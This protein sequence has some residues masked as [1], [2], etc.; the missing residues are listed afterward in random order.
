MNAAIAASPCPRCICTSPRLFAMS[1]ES[2]SRA[3]ALRN[4]GFGAVEIAQRLQ[5]DAELHVGAGNRGVLRESTR[6]D[7]RPRRACRRARGARRRGS[8]ALRH[9]ADRAPRR[10]AARPARHR[11][12][13]ST[14]AWRRDDSARRRAAATWPPPGGSGRWRR[15]SVRAGRARNRADRRRGPCPGPARAPLRTRPRRRP[16]LPSA[17]ARRRGRRAASASPATASAFG[18]PDDAAGTRG[19]R[20]G[21]QEYR[22]RLQ[23]SAR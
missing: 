15:P 22:Q 6:A 11:D 2:G 9:A 19:A 20:T 21:Q 7:V 18:C 4:D 10:A 16:S 5:R 23:S 17:R 13:A 12:R 8:T 14:T 1:S 3:R